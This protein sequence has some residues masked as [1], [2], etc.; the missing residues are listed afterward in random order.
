MP[1][2]LRSTLSHCFGF[3]SR[4]VCLCTDTITDDCIHGVSGDRRAEGR[5]V[6]SFYVFRRWGM[7]NAVDF[8]DS[9]WFYMFS[10]TCL[11][12]LHIHGSLSIFSPFFQHIKCNLL[13]LIC[14][15]EKQQFSTTTISLT[16][17]EFSP[18]SHSLIEFLMNFGSLNV[19]ASST[20]Q[21]MFN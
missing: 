18:C 6:L 2:T 5:T 14:L 3:S 17:K 9:I 20:K 16:F 13:P 10:L 19:K 11:C 15:G 1:L 12:T 21:F 7:M 8:M 4:S